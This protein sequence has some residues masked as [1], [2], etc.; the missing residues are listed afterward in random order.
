MININVQMGIAKKYEKGKKN[1]GKTQFHTSIEIFEPETYHTQ[2]EMLSTTTTLKY[3]SET[4]E[5]EDVGGALVPRSVDRTYAAIRST[6]QAIKRR[7]DWAG[8]LPASSGELRYAGRWAPASNT[9]GSREN[10]GHMAEEI[11]AAV[12]GG[13]WWMS[14]TTVFNHS[15]CSRDFMDIKSNSSDDDDDGS[16]VFQDFRKRPG[17]GTTTMQPPDSAFQMMDTNPDWNPDLLFRVQEGL[18]AF[19]T[20]GDDGSEAVTAAEHQGFIMDQQKPSIAFSS[21]SYVYPSS[22][23]ETLYHTSLPPPPSREPLYSFQSDSNGFSFH[24]SFPSMRPEEQVSDN[25]YLTNNTPFWN[26][27]TST[28]DDNISS[29]DSSPSSQF[30]HSSYKEK[31]SCSNL[32]TKPKHQEIQESGSMVKES[33]GE[34][35]FKRARL[36]TPSPLPTFKVRKEKLGDRITALQ[37]LVSPFGKTDTASVL[38]EAVEYIKLL[39]DQVNILGAPYMKNRE[40]KKVQEIQDHKMKGADEPKQDL[41]S[42]GLCLVPVSSMFP[43]ATEMTSGFWTPSFKGSFR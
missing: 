15:S 3:L 39:H 14:P 1:H 38:H 30:L 29:F 19:S 16:M 21:S 20:S 28:L 22:L 18:N 13:S 23:L 32:T 11:Q 33:S 36:D 26:A 35:P 10:L 6:V 24:Q 42:L 34:L 4:P 41:R 40:T 43:M 27:S 5:F 17:G 8:G 9:W 12:C 37:Q 7:D 31:R 2:Q 25:L